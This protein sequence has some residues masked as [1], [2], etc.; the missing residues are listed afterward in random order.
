MNNF[1]SSTLSLKLD[2]SRKNC[3][4]F[5]FNL[6]QGAGQANCFLSP[7]LQ[8]KNLVQVNSW[9]TERAFQ[10]FADSLVRAAAHCS[11]LNVFDQA[12][13]ERH[14]QFVTSFPGR[15]LLKSM[16]CLPIQQS[17]MASHKTTKVSHG[18]RSSKNLNQMT[19]HQKVHLLFQGLKQDYGNVM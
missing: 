12:I 10:I 5:L 9:L 19:L 14:R 1:T 7:G 16:K 13:K 4:N 15:R 6:I 2:Y 8:S 3:Q 18:A 17:S 11:L